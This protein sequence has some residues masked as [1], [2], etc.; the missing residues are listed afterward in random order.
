MVFRVNA[1]RN[2]GNFERQ[3]HINPTIAYTTPDIPMPVVSDSASSN[4]EFTIA[5]ARKKARNRIEPKTRSQRLPKTHSP[6]TLNATCHNSKWT[7]F[8][9]TNPQ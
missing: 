4:A 9:V 1:S 6:Y 7:K 3:G 2:S 8:V 5:E